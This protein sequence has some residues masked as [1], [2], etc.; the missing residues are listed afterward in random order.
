MIWEHLKKCDRLM[1]KL[2]KRAGDAA[3]KKPLRRLFVFGP[4]RKCLLAFLMQITICPLIAAESLPFQR[5][6]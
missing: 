4:M 5:L 6:V 1:Q 2:S 3:C